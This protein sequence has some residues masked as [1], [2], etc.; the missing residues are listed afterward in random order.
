MDKVMSYINYPIEKFVDK[1]SGVQGIDWIMNKSVTGL[2]S[3]VNDFSHKSVRPEAIYDEYRDNGHDHIY[4]PSN[5][6]TLDLEHVD[7]VV[8]FLAA[9]YKTLAIGQ[10]AGCGYAGAPGIPVD[11][12]ALTALNLRSLGEYA[13]Y[14]GFD[15]RSQE[16]RLFALKILQLSSS[17]TDGSKQVAMAQLVRL[18]KELARN[19]TWKQLETSSFVA[20]IQAI[21]KSLGIRLTKA[22]MA[23]LIPYISTLIGAGFNVYYTNKVCDSAFYLY[24]ERFLAKKYGPEIITSIDSNATIN[25]SDW[26]DIDLN[27]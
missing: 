10:G 9:K 13:T 3:L 23:D 2:F 21:C 8:G 11:I 18:S 25:V 27:D 15:I 26:D 5:I 17:P 1:V 14:Y 24:R 6:F 12:V 22:K 7:K 16:E 4:E 19:R 20:V